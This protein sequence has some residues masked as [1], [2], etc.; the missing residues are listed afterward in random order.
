MKIVVLFNLHSHT[1]VLEYEQW[2]RNTDLPTVN[3]LQ[4][5]DHFEICRTTGVMGSEASAPFG[6]IEII[7]VGDM[8]AFGSDV[9]SETMQRVA[10][11]FQS[12]ADNPV[13]ITTQSL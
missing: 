12:F 11:E 9:E 4:S 3:A 5:I 8:T 10:A 1:D 2:A 6:Y 13:F 7:D